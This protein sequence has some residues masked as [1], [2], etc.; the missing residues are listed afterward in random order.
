MRWIPLRLPLD[1]NQKSCFRKSFSSNEA[2]Y[3]KLSTYFQV[4]EIVNIFPNI[5][6][7]HQ[8]FQ[9]VNKFL[10][11]SKYS[12]NIWNIHQ[13]FKLFLKYFKHSSNFLNWQHISSFT[14]RSSNECQLPDVRVVIFWFFNV[15]V[16]IFW[17]FNVVVVIFKIV[18]SQSCNLFIF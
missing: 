11:Y 1:I 12:S 7:I 6:N 10:K 4:F 15:G 2:E 8:I 14:G 3:L 9:I 5:S 13:I 18:Y 17:L 16:V